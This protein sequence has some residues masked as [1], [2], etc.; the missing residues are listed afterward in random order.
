M[1]FSNSGCDLIRPLKWRQD[2]AECSDI[3]QI[4]IIEA[5]LEL[6]EMI[7]KLVLKLGKLLELEERQGGDSVCGFRMSNPQ[8][9]LCS[10]MPK[11]IQGAGKENLEL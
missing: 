4:N 11:E 7:H 2:G 1:A 10:W 8:L 6:T 9:D 5:T 3:G